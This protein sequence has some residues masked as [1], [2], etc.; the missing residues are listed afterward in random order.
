MNTTAAFILASL[1]TLIALLAYCVLA[2][3]RGVR[4]DRPTWLTMAAGFSGCIAWGII[5]L[6][7]SLT[8]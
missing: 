6:I 7:A 3:A 2:A 4:R 5:E 1:A 8:Q